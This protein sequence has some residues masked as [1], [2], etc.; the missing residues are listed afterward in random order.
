MTRKSVFAY[1]HSS[2]TGVCFYWDIY[3]RLNVCE[4]A[5]NFVV[6]LF[7]KQSDELLDVF[8]TYNDLIY[9]C[10]QFVCDKILLS[11][12]SSHVTDVTQSPQIM[13]HIIQPPK[14]SMFISNISWNYVTSEVKW[15]FFYSVHSW[16]LTMSFCTIVFILSVLIVL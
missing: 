11:M 7:Y 10:L 13:Y 2:K 8:T 5:A 3:G 4:S 14:M 16:F 12:F 9:I 1:F 15:I 6:F